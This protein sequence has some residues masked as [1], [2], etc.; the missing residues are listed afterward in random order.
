MDQ[1]IAT[2]GYQTKVVFIPGN[3]DP[4]C[5]FRQEGDTGNYLNVHFKFVEVFPKL[6]IAGFGGSVPGF[7]VGHKEEPAFL[8]YPFN[9]EQDVEKA[10]SS[11]LHQNESGI[12]N[13]QFIFV[14]HC[15]PM[16]SPTSILWENNQE[17]DTGSST[18]DKMLTDHSKNMVAYL[19]GHSHTGAGVYG[20]W[21]IRLKYEGGQSG[22]TQIQ[23]EFRRNRIV[24]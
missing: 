20:R 4:D 15:G 7:V 21:V 17:I 9:D 13:N 16:K 11:F 12:Q 1:L 6:Y 2:L 18:L 8:G 3:H 24:L 14:S 23:Q 10:L 19:H 5:L 22:I